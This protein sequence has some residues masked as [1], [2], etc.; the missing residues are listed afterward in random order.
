MLRQTT[1]R[2]SRLQA[3]HSCPKLWTKNS[4]HSKC[5]KEKN[6]KSHLQAHQCPL[7]ASHPIIHP[8]V[9]F[10][11]RGVLHPFLSAFV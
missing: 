1:E 8:D 11:V 6:T 9:T 2:A 4:E 5:T 7:T 10:V 3:S